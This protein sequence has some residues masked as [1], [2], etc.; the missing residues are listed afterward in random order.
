M[1]RIEL[2]KITVEGDKILYEV[3]QE[4]GVGLLRQNV[5]QLF[6]RLH[7]AENVNVSLGQV[8]QSILAVP[9]SL[10]L[11]PLVALPI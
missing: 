6:I 5:A 3:S 10:Y 4:N 1:K 11:L 8:P 2:S 9:I 7:C